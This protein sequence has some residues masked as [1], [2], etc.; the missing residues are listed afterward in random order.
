MEEQLSRSS[1]QTVVVPLLVGDGGRYGAMK[2]S[3]RNHFYETP[4]RMNRKTL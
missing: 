2:T 3:E 4:F 1:F